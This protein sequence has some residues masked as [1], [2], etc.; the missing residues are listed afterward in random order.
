MANRLWTEQENEY[1]R[2]HKDTSSAQLS[3]V[4]DRPARGI[5]QRKI[6]LGL[7]N[8]RKRISAEEMK[9]MQEKSKTMTAYKIAKDMGY[10]HST[11]QTLLK[12][13]INI[14]EEDVTKWLSKYARGIEKDVAISMLEIVMGEKFNLKKISKKYDDWREA[15]VRSSSL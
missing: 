13:R 9:V 10:S 8:P 3:Y 2:Q 4:L 12:E 15:Y 5:Q 6:A 11:I 14:K 7:C 1:L